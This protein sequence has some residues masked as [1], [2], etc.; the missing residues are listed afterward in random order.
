ML[1]QPTLEKIKG[2]LSPEEAT[3]LEADLKLAQDYRDGLNRTVDEVIDGW[4]EEVRAMDP[5]SA[6][7][8]KRQAWMN[9]ASRL[10]QA[11]RAKEK[12]EQRIEKH[13]E[14]LIPRRP[15]ETTWDQ[16]RGNQ[17]YSFQ[18]QNDVPW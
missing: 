5:G 15:G 11:I 8:K 12:A 6:D 16:A 7:P 10:V 2:V 14:E 13:R 18:G 1:D 9:K 17:R 4:P 3:A